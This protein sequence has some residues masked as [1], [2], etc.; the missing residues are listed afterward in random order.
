MAALSWGNTDGAGRVIRLAALLA[1]LAA[2]AASAECSKHETVTAFLGERYGE[3][4]GWIGRVG[5]DTVVELF[6]SDETQTWTLLATTPGGET[7]VLAWGNA[8]A[9]TGEKPGPNL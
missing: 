8:F 4:Q 2:P 9:F 6:V 3:A 5:N 7:C 1:V